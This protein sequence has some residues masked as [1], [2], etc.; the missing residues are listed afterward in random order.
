MRGPGP[1]T[2]QTLVFHR[3]VFGEASA[4]FSEY[5]SLLAEVPDSFREHDL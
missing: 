1:V 5:E 4:T 3:A 2:L